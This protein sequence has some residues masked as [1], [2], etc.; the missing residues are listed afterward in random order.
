M[1]LHGA[2]VCVT[3]RLHKARPPALAGST[4]AGDAL[5]LVRPRAVPRLLMRLCIESALNNTHHT[6]HTYTHP[7]IYMQQQAWMLV[8][9]AAFCARMGKPRMQQGVGPVVMCGGGGTFASGMRQ[10]TSV[11]L[12]DQPCTTMCACMHQQWPPCL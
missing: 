3:G 4:R 7:F 8:P 6:T 9:H 2:V 11:A 5:R 1:S 10:R 12:H